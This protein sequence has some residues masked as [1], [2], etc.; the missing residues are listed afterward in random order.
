MR[1][2]QALIDS[3]AKIAKKKAATA[4]RLRRRGRCGQN[5]LIVPGTTKL[6][7]LEE[8]LGAAGVELT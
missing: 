7:R 2:N 3:L 6:H 1:A 5:A 8:N 4:A